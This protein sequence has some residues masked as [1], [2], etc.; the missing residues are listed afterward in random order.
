MF[1]EWR[2]TA[3]GDAEEQSVTVPGKPDAFE[4]AEEVTYVSHFD[5]PRGENDDVAVLALHG[6]YAQS[7]VDVTGER[8]DGDGAVDHDAYFEPLRIPFLPYE[9][10]EVSVTCRRP[11]GRFG[12]LH[13]TDIVPDSEAVPGIWWDA[14]LEAHPLP[15][16][17]R[18]CVRPELSDDGAKLHIRTTVV[19]EDPIDERIT[20]SLR[21]QGDVKTR[22]MM[23]RREVTT[24]GPGK[25]TVEHS[26][27]VL[28]PALW[29]PHELGDQHHYT[30]RAKLGDHERT[31][32]TGISDITYDDGHLLVNGERLP[33]RGVAL[34]TSAVEDVERA[35]DVNAN[36][37]RARAQA[38]PPAVY[39]ACDRAGLLV[40]QD[41]P[42]TGPGEFDTDRGERLARALADTYSSHPSLAAFGVHDEP[43]NRFPD[44]LGSGFF[45]RLR[46]RWR[47]WRTSY[48]R[49]PA[50]TVAA[51]LPSHRPVFPVVGEPGVDHDAAAYYPGWDYGTAADIET[52][53]DRYPAE[54]VAAFGA[55][56]LGSA[57]DDAA[58]FDAAKHAARASDDVEESQNYQAAV[59]R[60]V[61]E[62]TRQR[63]LSTIATALRDTDDAGMGVYTVD[64]SAKTAQETL[65]TVFEPVQVFLDRSGTAPAVVV[66][67]DQPT[68]LTATVR[69]ETA[70]DSDELEATVGATGQWSTTIDLPGDAEEVTLAVEG[71]S[72]TVEHHYDL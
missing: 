39:E 30:L 27:E 60:T 53:L 37:V 51:A 2:A 72:E 46:L 20:Y 58:G 56:S 8:L 55:G 19:S 22:G 21:P 16:I 52:L 9:D 36:L 59:L 6:L 15:Y 57:V 49:G 23:N 68:A 48:D 38:L 40:W 42:L 43:T 1:D 66:V 29:W 5:D 25:T 4:G 69:W 65:S 14:S 7:T 47:A 44:S 41:L 63:R 61:T 13:D 33:I 71:H 35:T 64:G 17:D 32:T 45:D 50:E 11:E 18:M 62:R 26:I 3:V 28:D 24:N 67:N 31:V 34:H 10:N 70:E 54:L 12:G